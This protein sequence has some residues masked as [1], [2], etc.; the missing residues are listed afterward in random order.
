[1]SRLASAPVD[2]RLRRHEFRRDVLKGL[3]G[4]KKRLPCKYF[5]DARGS[6]LFERICELEE[7]YLTRTEIAIMQE[8]AR[9]MT[10]RIGPG[11]MLVELGSG[12]S[13]KTRRLLDH[14]PRPA[15]YVPVDISRAPLQRSARQ[16][17][18]TYP[19]IEVRPLCADFMQ[20]FELPPSR[21]D[22]SHVTVY[23]PG[24]TIGNFPPRAAHGLLGQIGRLVGGGGGLLIGI[25][26]VKDPAALNAAYNDRRG[27]TAQFN[28]NLLRRINRELRG[29]FDLEHFAHR[30]FYNTDA[31]RM[32]I[33][34]ESL[35]PQRVSVAGRVFE[36][37]RGERIHTEYSYKYTVDGFCHLARKANFELEQ[38]WTDGNRMFAVLYLVRR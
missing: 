21:N 32:E 34:L 12:C 26:L 15:V 20:A 5:Y 18:E 6:G 1:M 23:F 25:D 36:F 35:A 14:L 38:A 22:V 30:A 37:A 27:V 8:H 33:F 10:G 13:V 2:L 31:R 17:R 3:S 28:L 11:C 29:D 19:E 4:A 16:L 7:Y 24:S 9:E